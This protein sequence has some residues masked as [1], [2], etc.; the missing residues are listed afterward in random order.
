MVRLKRF[1]SPEGI[2]C[3]SHGYARG[4][5]DAHTET[6]GFNN[7]VSGGLYSIQQIN[8]S[9]NHQILLGVSPQ[10]S[11]IIT[12]GF[13]PNQQINNSTTQQLNKFLAEPFLISR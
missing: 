12:D 1:F 10:I 7:Y 9:T 4:K 5:E 8:N 2:H 6:P 13:N 3:I 11:Q